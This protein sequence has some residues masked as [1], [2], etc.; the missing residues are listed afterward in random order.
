M[1]YYEIVLLRSSAPSLTYCTLQALTTGTVVSV[2]LKTTIKEAVVIAEVEKPVFE[3]A[4][5]LSVTDKVYS[6]EQMEIAKFI[7]EY[8]FS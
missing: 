4:E 8:Y 5:I 1:K 6:S 7:S 2:P 3:T